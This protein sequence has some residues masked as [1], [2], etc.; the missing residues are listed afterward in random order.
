MNV[1][2]FPKNVDA[3]GEE[4]KV[5]VRGESGCTVKGWGVG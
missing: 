5:V 3:T 2:I 4:G 1:V